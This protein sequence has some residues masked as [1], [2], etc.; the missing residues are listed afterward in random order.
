MLIPGSLTRLP[1]P[2]THKRINQFA[3]TTWLALVVGLG[4]AF[5]ACTTESVTHQNDFPFDGTGGKSD[6]FGR[7][8]AGIAAP[9]EA[10][11][12]LREREDQ[13]AARMQLRRAEAWRIVG[14]VL[15]PV[16][17][18]GLA[19][20]AERGEVELADGEVPHV[21][22]FQTWYGVDD[23]QRMFQHLYE[24][25]GAVNRAAREPFDADAI[26]DAIE[27]NA[28]AVDR[29]SRWPLDRYL[30]YVDRLGV[31]PEGTP[32]DE[33]VR[34]IQSNF[35]GAASGNARI[36]YSPATMRH[37]L[38]SYGAILNCLDGLEELTFAA[39]PSFDNFTFC[40]TE[41]FPADAVLIKAQWVRADFGMELPVY[42]T[43]ARTIARH[44]SPSNSG[45]WGE[46]DRT[47][48]PSSDEIY[49][50]RLR[51]E[52]TYR[53]AGF[54]IMTKETRHWMWIT[55]WWSDEPD[56]DFGADRPA[57]LI[58]QLDPVF[59][60][61]KMCVV[62]DYEEGDSDPAEAFS[63]YPTLAAALSASGSGPTWCSNAYVEHG[64]GNARTNCI[65]CHQHGGSLVGDD[66]RDF[67]LDAVIQ[68]ERLYPDT[69]RTRIRDVFPGD[70]L[71]SLTRVDDIRSVIVRE[72]GHFDQTDGDPRVLGI[73]GMNGDPIEGEQLF[74][75]H[76]ARCHGDDGFGASG[77]DL[78]ARFATR[79]LEVLVTSVIEGKGPM[80]VWGDELSDEE[81]AD[82]FA[83]LVRDFGLRD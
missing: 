15:D 55:L 75:D 30:R 39:E 2:R 71:W 34:R 46:G 21:P 5:S 42:D 12:S 83:F 17:L 80:P 9:Y 38:E 6:V 58:D 36:A 74:A 78:T 23:F 49:T 22:R 20:R 51:D 29:S 82:L 32:E 47:A 27:W 31:C 81:L 52:S 77:P 7:S 41:E 18:L 19:D 67:D 56:T 54:H 10:D 25:H 26:D 65:G 4:S 35:S 43:H 69:G 62:S 33:C 48:N 3:P 72:V 57:E 44:L 63:A 70:Y 24:E 16:P 37:L 14:R 76:C 66:L 1:T 59:A 11:P 73:L 8:L 61:Y 45:D 79:E 68:D 13:L 50:I 64:R 28:T 53:L 40:F 60:N